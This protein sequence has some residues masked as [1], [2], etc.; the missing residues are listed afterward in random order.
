MHFFVNTESQ[1]ASEAKAK[2]YTEA[3]CVSSKEQ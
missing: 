2:L 1:T 3:L